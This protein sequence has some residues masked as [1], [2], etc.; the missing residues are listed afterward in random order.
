MYHYVRPVTDD[1]PYF[2]NM[3]TLDFINQ[4]DYFKSNFGFI[5]K[6]KFLSVV[7]Q[8]SENEM[9][10]GVVLTFDDAFKDHY[11]YVFP[12]LVKRKTF[13]IF[14]IATY[15][16]LTGKILD[17]HRVHLL[18]GKYGGEVIF[19]LIKEIVSDD[20]ILDENMEKF[21]SKIYKAQSNDDYT[22][23]VKKTLNY[24]VKHEYRELVVDALMSKLFPNEDEI[25]SKFYMSKDNI[26]EMSRSGMI[27]GSHTVNHNVMSRLTV[28][29]QKKE[30]EE[31]FMFLSDL[32]G[33]Q[34][35]KTFCYP[36]GG[37]HSFTNE[38]ESI[39]DENECVFSF[40]VE[41]RDI[42]S[43][44]I[45]NNYQKLPR[46]NCNTFFPIIKRDDYA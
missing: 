40:N 11:Q 17:V 15:P 27:I 31:S 39:L 34:R 18:L 3:D 16:Y 5:N 2:K 6:K 45:I 44:D 24:Y 7:T 26:V 20:M 30:I 32:L 28:D 12:E 9:T 1:F 33:T 14:Y 19:N 37:F 23:C 13:G 35:I 36:Y 42:E 43:D 29:E 25:Y 4:L 41:Q 38:T 10:K 46:Y 8:K 22:N 21:D